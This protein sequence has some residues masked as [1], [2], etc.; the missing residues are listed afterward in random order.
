MMTSYHVFLPSPLSLSEKNDD[1]DLSL[2]R[3]AQWW[4]LL[5]FTKI[6]LSGIKK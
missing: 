4:R 2:L 3:S 5:F 6:A 1:R